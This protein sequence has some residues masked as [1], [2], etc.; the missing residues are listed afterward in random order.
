[1]I[2][3]TQG[4][5]V[6]LLGMP[7]LYDSSH[8]FRRLLLALEQRRLPEFMYPD[9]AAAQLTKRL[10]LGRPRLRSSGTPMFKH[11]LL[12]LTRLRRSS[13]AASMYS[14]IK[15]LKRDLDRGHTRS[16]YK[17]MRFTFQ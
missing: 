16:R 3:C 6:V 11:R 2:P 10:R 1:M 7:P 4:Q 12:R 13:Q 15:K 5:L 9:H 14:L 17:R 8:G